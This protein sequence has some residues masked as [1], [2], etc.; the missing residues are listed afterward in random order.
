MAFGTKPDDP[1]D[2][3]GPEASGTSCFFSDYPG[4]SIRGYWIRIFICLSLR[5]HGMD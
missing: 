3:G 1:G 2:Y 5:K 4:E